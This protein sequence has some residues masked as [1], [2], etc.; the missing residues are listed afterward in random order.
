[1]TTPAITDAV[2][3]PR[4]D[5]LLIAARSARLTTVVAPAGYGKTTLLASWGTRAKVAWH[6][7]TDRDHS[8]PALL[9]RLTDVLRAAVPELRFEPPAVLADDEEAGEAGRTDRAHAM[10]GSLCDAVGEATARGR[11]P[12]LLVLDDVHLVGPAAPL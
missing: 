5:H 2:A 12:L 1:M 8:V 9:D 4:L 6:T 3:R 11:E 7:V 10:A